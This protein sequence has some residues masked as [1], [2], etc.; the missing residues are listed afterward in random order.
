MQCN[1]LPLNNPH[2]PSPAF[3]ACTPISA[4]GTIR[5]LF[6]GDSITELWRG[7]LWGRA[8]PFLGAVGSL[9]KEEFPGIGVPVPAAFRG[10]GPKV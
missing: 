4:L 1:V 3:T 6:L 9:L 2:C 7:E 8:A 5:L 10:A